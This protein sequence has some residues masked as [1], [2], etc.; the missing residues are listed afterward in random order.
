M[1]SFFR[2][3][4]EKISRYLEKKKRSYGLYLFESLFFAL[5]LFIAYMKLSVWLDRGS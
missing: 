5:I 2:I 3:T 1:W 4:Q